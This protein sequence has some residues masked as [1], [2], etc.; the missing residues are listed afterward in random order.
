MKSAC[1]NVRTLSQLSGLI[2]GSQFPSEVF[3]DRIDSRRKQSVI[4]CFKLC[5]LRTQPVGA[6]FAV[7]GS[8]HSRVVRHAELADDRAAA[9]GKDHGR[10]GIDHGGGLCG[11]DIGAAIEY[12]RG[13]PDE[14]Y[15]QRGQKPNHHDRG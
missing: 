11:H 8:Y 2:E 10:T 6:N 9:D 4:P 14:G 12:A 5:D 13:D 15:Q 1:I 7:L 3:E